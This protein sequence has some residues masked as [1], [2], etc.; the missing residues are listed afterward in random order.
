MRFG[1]VL[2][3]AN[4][5]GTILP[6]LDRILAQLSLDDHVFCVLD[7]VSRDRTRAVVEQ[8]AAAEGRVACVWAPEN[9]CVVHA[10][11]RGYRAAMEA[12]SDCI[13][14]MDAG[15]SHCPEEIPQF[16]RAMEE[17]YDFAGGCRFMPGGS[18]E[19]SI[20]RRVVSWGGSVLANL[21]LGTRMKDM[22][23]G[24]ECFNRRAMEL[25]LAKGVR[26]QAHFFQTEIRFLM[27]RL[28]WIEV[29]ITYRNPSP[30]VG[31]SN[32]VEAFG[33]LG[34]MT[35]DGFRKAA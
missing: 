11:F 16:R 6:L 14:E 32:V 33:G 22:T 29:P 19:G 23:G 27:H 20:N 24:F 28:R 8:Y 21:L 5:E 13:L 26:S 18:H 10:Y 35:Y 4:V 7:H 30:S 34:R 25:V 3:L 1:V 2:P 15:F 31:S 17:G 9:R 12:G